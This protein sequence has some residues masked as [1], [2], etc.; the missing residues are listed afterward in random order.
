MSVKIKITF[1][2][3]NCGFAIQGGKISKVKNPM[4]FE[5]P[6]GWVLS[7]DGRELFCPKCVAD[8]IK[9]A[10]ALNLI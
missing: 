6:E 9:Q 10:K 5:Y 2:C 7:V 4:P 8:Q 1:Q 3:N